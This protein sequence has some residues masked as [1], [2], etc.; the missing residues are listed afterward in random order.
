M[1]ASTRSLQVYFWHVAT[2]KLDLCNDFASAN[3]A[4]RDYLGVSQAGG[5]SPGAAT[6][7]AARPR[8]R[9]E[10]GAE[11]HGCGGGPLFG[12][13]FCGYKLAFVWCSSRRRLP[14]FGA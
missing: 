3:A 14:L 11:E 2:A 4:K 5:A 7:P 1:D 12:A 8:V 6:P 10:V 9:D 13:W